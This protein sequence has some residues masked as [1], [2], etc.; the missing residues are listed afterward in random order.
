MSKYMTIKASF[1]IKLLTK[2]KT[3]RNVGATYLAITNFSTLNPTVG[4]IL[5][6]CDDSGFN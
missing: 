6:V 5:E 4:T 2:I 1:N 3:N